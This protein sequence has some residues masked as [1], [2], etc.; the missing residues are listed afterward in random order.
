MDGVLGGLLTTFSA[1]AAT[2]KGGLFVPLLGRT[3]IGLDRR[4][5]LAS[6]TRRLIYDLIE[7]TPGIPVCTLMDRVELGWGT[8]YHHLHKMERA[9]LIHT[10]VSGRRRLV[11]PGP[12]PSEPY[13]SS[14]A[15]ALVRGR[16]ARRVAEALVASPGASVSKIAERA[17]E[18]PR[19]T[20]YHL[21]R[22]LDAGLATSSSKTR[23]TGLAA[24]PP[25]LLALRRVPRPP[26]LDDPKE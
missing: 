2:A 7:A 1:L 24:T 14:D 22:F 23:H 21:K 11:F 3:A 4:T 25:L 17:G 18:S 13:V 12:V 10:A 26:D 8:L 16:T 6:P 19:A 5:V 20:Y 15:F 9:G